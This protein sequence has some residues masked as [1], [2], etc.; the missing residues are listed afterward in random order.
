VIYAQ[1]YNFPAKRPTAALIERLMTYAWPGNVR[2]LR[3]AVERA[4][5]LNDGELLTLADFPFLESRSGTLQ[6]AS[7][8]VARLDA[9]EKTAIVNALERYKNNV[10]RAAH[11]LGITRTSLHRRMKKYGL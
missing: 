5:I 1:K 2:E 10:S 4:V 3:H 7:D 9:A 11:A 8:A 6:D